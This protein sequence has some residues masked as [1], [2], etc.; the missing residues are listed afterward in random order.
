MLT[1]LFKLVWNKQKNKWTIRF[2][3][4]GRIFLCIEK[5][6]EKNSEDQP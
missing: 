4:Q 2:E 6:L 5:V 3:C 1:A